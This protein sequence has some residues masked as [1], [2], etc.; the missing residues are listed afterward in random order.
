[1]GGKVVSLLKMTI[2]AVSQALLVV[3]RSGKLRS[4]PKV[5]AGTGVKRATRFL[6]YSARKALLSLGLVCR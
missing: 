2:Q 3:G 6:G 1:M 4:I 5:I